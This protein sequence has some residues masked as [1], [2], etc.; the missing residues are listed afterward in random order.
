MLGLALL[1]EMKSPAAITSAQKCLRNRAWELRSLAFRYL[2]VNRDVTSIPLLIS[3]Y[4][5]EEGRLKHE[6][7]TA[8]FLHTGK[9]L[10]AGNWNKWWRKSKGFALPHPD[11]VKGGGTTTGG[12]TVSYYDMPLV[13]S[14]IAFVVDHSGSMAARSAQQEAHSP[15]R[16]QGAADERGRELAQDAKVGVIFFE[17][18]IV[19]LEGGEG[20]SAGNRREL[21][22]DIQAVKRAWRHEP[23]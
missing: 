4:G 17:S 6:L 11:T 12:Q 20:M 8:L 18:A 16:R 10:D 19:R 23:L 5:A 9:L 15:R 14:R 13:S 21:L 22:D 3:R 1:L 2:A 7:E